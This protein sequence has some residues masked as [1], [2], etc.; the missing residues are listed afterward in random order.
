MWRLLVVPLLLL[1]TAANE[2]AKP[3]LTLAQLRAQYAD[4]DSRY[5]TIGGMEVHYK[6]EGPRRAGTPVLLLVHGSQ[7][8]LKSWD[9]VVPLLKRR[10]RLIRFDVPGLG[11]SGDVPDSALSTVR[12]EDV[13]E[14]LL[15]RLNI[16]KVTVIG[17]SSGGTLATFLAAKRPDLIERVVVSNAPSDPVVTT[18]LVPTAGWTAAQAEAKA[19]GFQGRG[20]W[21]AFLDYFSPGNRID[22]STRRHFYAFSRRT[23]HKNYISMIARVADAPKARAAMAAVRAPTLLI[24]GSN[25]PLLPAS[26]GRTLRDYFSGTD[27][28]IVYMPGVGHFPPFEEPDRFARIALA[29]IE[30]A[31]PKY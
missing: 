4:A 22:E 23:P 21:D 3:Y 16:P 11:L 17:F 26:A 1:L 27:A 7:C 10:Y 15:C 25:D 18:H 6:D 19:T 29:W 28:A 24:W 8:T 13:A 31:T 14:E 30:A 12:P 20:Y 2:P 5:A 9:A